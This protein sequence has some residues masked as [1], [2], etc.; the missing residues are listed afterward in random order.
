MIGEYIIPDK[1][2]ERFLRR[3]IR[4][5]QKLLNHYSKELETQI[6]NKQIKIQ[7]DDKIV[8]INGIEYEIIGLFSETSFLIMNDDSYY[9]V[10]I[11]FIYE[12]F[13]YR[14]YDKKGNLI[15]PKL[16]NIELTNTKTLLRKN[17]NT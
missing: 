6:R 10:S 14:E 17:E 16:S 3:R 2:I 4:L 13:K 12:S 1:K 7:R 11:P 5:N 9:E 15:I 8:N